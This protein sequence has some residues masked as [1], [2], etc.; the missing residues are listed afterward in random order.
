MP[1]S[2]IAF[3][4]G[5]LVSLNSLRRATRSPFQSFCSFCQSS[6]LPSAS[7]SPS[8]ASWNSSSPSS[9]GLLAD[10]FL[11][12]FSRSAIF[13]SFAAIDL[14]WS[15]SFFVSAAVPPAPALGGAADARPAAALSI[16]LS[17]AAA[18]AVAFPHWEFLKRN[19]LPGRFLPHLQVSM[20][21]L[22]KNCMPS[23][24]CF[25]VQST[26]SQSSSPGMLMGLPL[27]PVA[28]QTTGRSRGPMPTNAA[29]RVRWCESS[30]DLADA[31]RCS[32]T[33]RPL[34][35]AS[36]TMRARWRRARRFLC[37]A[38]SGFVVIAGA[39]LARVG[40]LLKNYY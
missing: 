18:L 19:G 38:G 17:A 9:A 11:I 8:L 12:S 20:W 21:L 10:A 29:P 4:F 36:T 26:H 6:L 32:P 35:A 39:I 25:A 22:Q 34:L 7:S 1:S 2:T 13:L 31:K 14:W 3:A 33:L 24:F 27:R 30:S 37:Q 40:M 23:S 15:R 28:S 16:A 5:H